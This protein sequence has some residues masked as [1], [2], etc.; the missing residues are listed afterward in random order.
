MK[1]CNWVVRGDS[2]FFCPCLRDKLRSLA[3]GW[4]VR[5]ASDGS[6]VDGA[7]VSDVD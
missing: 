6:G 3:E 7:K 5:N 1:N 2:V 4:E